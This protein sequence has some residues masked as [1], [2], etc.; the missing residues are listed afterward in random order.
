[1]LIKMAQ[2]IGSRT[3]APLLKGIVTLYDPTHGKAL[4]KPA[5][6]L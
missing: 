5:G 4:L 1:M 2:D 3:K 6:S